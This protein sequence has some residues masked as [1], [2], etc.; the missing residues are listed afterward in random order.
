MGTFDTLNQ[1]LLAIE[2]KGVI[3]GG[4]VAELM[5]VFYAIAIMLNNDQ[6]PQ[7]RTERWEKLRRVFI[8]AG[9]IAAATVIIGAATGLAGQ[10]K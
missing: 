4:T 5:V 2:G 9:I 7:A 8:C 3:I 10:L 6:S 1:L